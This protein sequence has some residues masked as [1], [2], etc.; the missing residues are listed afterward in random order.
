LCQSF[1]IRIPLIG[2]LFYRY[3]L[4]LF[5]R[6]AGSLIESGLQ[7][8][9]AY[10]NAAEVLSLIPLRNE[11]TKEASAVSRGVPFGSAVAKIKRIPPF[12]PPLV[13][14]G[15]VSG[16]LGRS[17][18]RAADILD[19]GVD[20]SLK[21][22]TALIEPVMMAGMGFAVGAI[23]LSIMMPIYDISKVLQK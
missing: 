21:K 19:R 17:L 20:H 16:A 12:V 15:E 2:G 22:I 14:A 5:L 13:S 8:A 18:L 7:S 1:L 23:A 6:S 10:R 4:S 11:L 3:S 9:I